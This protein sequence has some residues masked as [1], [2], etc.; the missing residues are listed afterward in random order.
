MVGKGEKSGRGDRPGRI[1]KRGGTRVGGK[2]RL[3]EKDVV[4]GMNGMAVVKGAAKEEMILV[5]LEKVEGGRENEDV[6]IVEEKCEG[7]RG[8]VGKE[9]GKKGLVEKEE[10]GEEEIRDVEMGL[11]EGRTSEGNGLGDS[12]HRVEGMKF[13]DAERVWHGNMMKGKGVVRKDRDREEILVVNGRVYRGI[14]KREYERKWEEMEKRKR[15]MEG[16]REMDSVDRSMEESREARKK[17][18]REEEKERNRELDGEVLEWG[19]EMWKEEKVAKEKREKDERR[20]RE[21]EGIIR[22]GREK[23]LD[24]EG[25]LKLRRDYK[26]WEEH[27]EGVRYV[28]GVDWDKAMS[29]VVDIDVRKLEKRLGEREDRERERELRKEEEEKGVKSVVEVSEGLRYSWEEEDRMR[30]VEVMVPVEG[31]RSYGEVARGVEVGSGEKEVEE[32]EVRK[33][34]ER[35]EEVE[36]KMEREERV[37]NCF[38]VVMDSREEGSGE[39]VDLRDLERELGMREGAIKKVEGKGKRVKVEV[40][41]KVDL[42]ISVGMEKG[43]WGELL[44]GE[45]VEVRRLDQWAGMVLAG[46]EVKVWEN[47]MGELRERLEVENNTKLMKEPVWLADER[48]RKELNLKHVG[49]VIHVARESERLKYLEEGMCF[50]GKKLKMRRF[51][52]RKELEFCTKCGVVGHSWWRCKKGKM[53]CSVCAVPGHAGW[54]HRC[55]RCKVWRKPCIHYRKCAMC[56]GSHTMKE[57]NER[58]CWGVRMEMVRLKALD[59]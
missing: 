40:E 48:K 51:V 29:F 37:G 31:G 41:D 18:E 20:K 16:R 57:A 34:R 54:E 30:K 55:G 49:V 24:R 32:M 4:M 25:A 45:E 6:M 1:E 33:M 27:V 47:W 12:K 3:E 56:G 38:E 14:W 2:R 28:L 26:I 11:G 44:K 23:G 35:E 36:K 17:V 15:D 39:E 58:N 7:G 46:M 59:C 5:G 43:K 10:G 22:R 53:V 50:D 52:D 9:C 13:G 42:E 8:L 21:K 19:I